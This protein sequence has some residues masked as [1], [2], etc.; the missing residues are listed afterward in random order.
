MIVVSQ[1]Q[2]EEKRNFSYLIDKTIEYDPLSQTLLYD[3]RVSLKS[4]SYDCRFSRTTKLTADVSI[5]DML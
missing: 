5:N 1:E 4:L 2:H 3:V